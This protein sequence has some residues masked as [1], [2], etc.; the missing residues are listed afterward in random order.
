V[1]DMADGQISPVKKSTSY[2]SYHW[3]AAFF[4][5][6]KKT[7]PLVSFGPKLQNKF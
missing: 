3:S 1:D 4:I 6:R 5:D 7:L 2:S